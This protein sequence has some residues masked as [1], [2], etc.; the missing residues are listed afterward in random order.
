MKTRFARHIQKR[1]RLKLIQSRSCVL[2]VLL[3]GCTAGASAQDSNK[4][5]TLGDFAFHGYA[6]AGISATSQGGQGGCYGSATTG[7][8]TGRV[9]DE[10]DTYVEFVLDKS[11]QEDNPRS[12][13]L[14]TRFSVET[15]KDA[16]F[17]DYQSF[18]EP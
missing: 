1:Q 17:N 16:Q 10:C 9:G 8:Y 12:W 5:D 15:A 14:N 4:V 3:I 13:A 11:H 7:R 18:T 2:G 6:R